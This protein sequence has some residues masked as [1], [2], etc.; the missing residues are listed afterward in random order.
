M[1]KLN[2]NKQMK[3]VWKLPAIAPWEKSCTKL[4]TQKPMSVLTRIILASIKP[5]AWILGPFSG[6]STTGIAANLL[7]SRFVGIDIE[8]E[9]LDISIARKKEIENSDT[10][11]SYRSKIK[12]FQGKSN[13]GKYLVE[14][15]SAEYSVEDF[16]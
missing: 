8:K 6:S 12:G 2:D 7:N 9:Y 1:K 3:D 5:D 13:L 10:A 15:P 16:L 4:P 14:E 11:D